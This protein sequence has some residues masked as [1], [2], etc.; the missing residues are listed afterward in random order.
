MWVV[1]TSFL[2]VSFA[3]MLPVA[4]QTAIE[5]DVEFRS[6]LPIDYLNYMGVVHSDSVSC[7]TSMYIHTLRAPL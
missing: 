1:F 2:W 3:Q 6:S 7:S 5:S 4:L